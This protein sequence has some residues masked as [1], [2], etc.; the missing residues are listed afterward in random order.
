MEPAAFQALAGHMLGADGI[1]RAQLA[2]LKRLR[3]MI[4]N[5]PRLLH[6]T[7]KRPIRIGACCVKEKAEAVRLRI[8]VNSL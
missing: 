8:S 6:Q 5:M 4:F 1:V 7:T 2:H 3:Q